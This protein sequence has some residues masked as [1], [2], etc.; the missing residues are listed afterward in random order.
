[1]DSVPIQITPY[2]C[3]EYK[4]SVYP[5]NSL[6]N[7]LIILVVVFRAWKTGVDWSMSGV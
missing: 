6:S 5:S 3:K 1:M 4:R 7:D 2:V